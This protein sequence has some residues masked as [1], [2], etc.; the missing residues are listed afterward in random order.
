M[1]TTI[2]PLYYVDYYEI[3]RV[4]MDG[5]RSELVYSDFFAFDSTIKGLAVDIFNNVLFWTVGNEIKYINLTD[6][7]FMW[8]RVKQLGLTLTLEANYQK[9]GHQWYHTSVYTIVYTLCP[10]HY[11]AIITSPCENV[12]M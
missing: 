5:Q 1:L 12:S 8:V 4:Q 6:W 2:V 3:K 11:L 7:E 9:L 10:I